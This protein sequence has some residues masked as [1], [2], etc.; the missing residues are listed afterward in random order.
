MERP[1]TLRRL[2]PSGLPILV[3]LAACRP[4]EE[5]ELARCLAVGEG[6]LAEGRTGPESAAL[7]LPYAADAAPARA[8]RQFT[9]AE[10][11]RGGWVVVLGPMDGANLRACLRRA[12][13]RWPAWQT[14]VV[15]PGAL[16]MTTAAGRW[17]GYCCSCPVRGSA[18]AVLSAAGPPG[19]QPASSTAHSTAAP[20]RWIQ[21]R[22][23][24]FPS[25]T[26]S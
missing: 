1:D 24:A 4:P 26:D 15:L 22:F 2:C 19:M 11:T 17:P 23:M 10:N 6:W 5:A 3:Q 12:E 14:W 20:M 13:V 8:L 25:F 7:L 9:R 18:E 16:S 21:M